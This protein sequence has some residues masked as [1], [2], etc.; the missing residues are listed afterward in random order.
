MARSRARYTREVA[1]RLDIEGGE[2]SSLAHPGLLGG[3][4][5][6]GG[7]PTVLPIRQLQIEVHGQSFIDNFRLAEL[8]HACGLALFSKEPNHWGC[9]GYKCVELSFV[10]PEQAWESYVLSHPSCTP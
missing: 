7:R 6:N 3:C 2:F 8:M 10:A 9:F 4:I 1:L 5:Q